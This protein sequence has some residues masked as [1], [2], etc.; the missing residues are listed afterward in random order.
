MASGLARALVESSQNVEELCTRNVVA[1]EWLPFSTQ[2][3]SAKL[4]YPSVF[5]KQRQT[6]LI[7]FDLAKVTPQELGR[8]SGAGAVIK[9]LIFEIRSESSCTQIVA[10]CR[11]TLLQSDV[12]APGELLIL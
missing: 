5:K 4:G 7:S 10:G 12:G 1:R 3:P 6:A 11:S 9:H 2:W 8:R